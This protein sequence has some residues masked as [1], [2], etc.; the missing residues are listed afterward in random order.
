MKTFQDIADELFIQYGDKDGV[1][2]FVYSTWGNKEITLSEK[3][4]KLEIFLS[5]L[6][7]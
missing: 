1:I 6:K 5:T 2:D 4:K 3:I 7:K